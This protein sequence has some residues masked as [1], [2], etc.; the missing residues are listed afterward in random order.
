MLCIS[1]FLFA[2]VALL[3]EMPSFHYLVC[4]TQHSY[5][6]T[7]PTFTSQ[8]ELA[9]TL[10]V[11]ITLRFYVSFPSSPPVSELFEGRSMSCVSASWHGA[12]PGTGEVL[13]VYFLS[14][15]APKPHPE[16]SV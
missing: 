12:E 13:S 7:H 8:V 4:K 10:T 5:L 9:H 6:I 2:P 14:P 15:L 16:R 11:L 1:L 3:A